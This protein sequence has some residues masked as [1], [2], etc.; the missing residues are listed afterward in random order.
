MLRIFFLF[1]LFSQT[2]IAQEQNF[3]KPQL[4]EDLTFLK[5]QLLKKHPNLFTY[6]SPAALDHFFQTCTQELPEQ[7]TGLA[8]YQMISPVSKLIKDGHT[9]SFKFII[10]LIYY[11]NDFIC[12]E[13]L[14]FKNLSL[15]K[16]ETHS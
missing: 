1:L 11:E 16:K 2:L 5:E 9:L 6:S 15:S 12:Y 14:G 7:A 13:V 8:F 4:A 10:S 3:S